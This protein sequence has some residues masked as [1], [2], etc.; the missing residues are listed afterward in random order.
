MSNKI[1]KRENAGGE[2]VYLVAVETKRN[3]RFMITTDPNANIKSA[4][5]KVEKKGRKAF[6]SFNQEVAFLKESEDKINEARFY[7][8]FDM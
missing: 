3:R 8:Q 1:I 7:A 2:M 6:E 5:V 4:N